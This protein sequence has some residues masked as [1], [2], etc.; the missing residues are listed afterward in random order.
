MTAVPSLGSYRPLR[1]QS[2]IVT[3]AVHELLRHVPEGDGRVWRPVIR[4]SWVHRLY[5]GDELALTRICRGLDH[6]L[7][8]VER[9]TWAWRKV[10]D[11]VYSLRHNGREVG[12]IE[13]LVTPQQG[14]A[15][16]LNR[17]VAGLN[18]HD[19]R[20]PIPFPTDLRQAS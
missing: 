4:V 20:I 5:P 8:E 14:F 12:E 17:M 7:G 9:T 11:R 19:A 13:F 1:W 6:D 3:T 18:D 16:W 15:Y 10:N 2:R